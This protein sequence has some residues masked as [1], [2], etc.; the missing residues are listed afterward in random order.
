MTPQDLLGALNIGA[1]KT[2]PSVAKC[3]L[4]LVPG[5]LEITL[6]VGGSAVYACR[7]QTCGFAGDGLELFAR[8]KNCGLQEAA[9]ILLAGGILP[10][11]PDFHVHLQDYLGA[12]KAHQVID[13]WWAERNQRLQ[14]SSHAAGI[15]QALGC[16]IS[17]ALTLDPQ[18]L[19]KHLGICTGRELQTLMSGHEHLMYTQGYRQ[20]LITPLYADPRTITGFAY[21]TETDFGCAHLDS[22]SKVFGFGFLS[23]TGFRSDVV[24]LV[25]TPAAALEYLANSWGVPGAPGI[26]YVHP[27]ASA[28]ESVLARRRLFLNFNDSIETYKQTLRD[29]SAV[30]VSKKAIQTRHYGPLSS[31]KARLEYFLEI[32][33]TA[34]AA[35]G[36]YLLG[37]SFAEAR[38]AAQSMDLRGADMARISSA[39]PEASR[40][41]M[42]EIFA[43]LQEKLSVSYRGDTISIYNG[44][45]RS[46]K[47]GEISNAVFL[48]D[49]VICDTHNNRTVAKGVVL[50]GKQTYPFQDDLVRLQTKVVDFLQEVLRKNHGDIL[51]VA[52]GWTKGNKMY[53]LS[54]QFR[55]PQT[56]YS[57]VGTGWANDNKRLVLPRITL[58]NG[59]VV[60][61]TKLL[62]GS[63]QGLGIPPDL[64][65]LDLDPILVPSDA[66]ASFW[67]LWAALTANAWGPLQPHGPQGYGIV[68]ATGTAF[69]EVY[70]GMIESIGLQRVTLSTTDAVRTTKATEQ[71]SILPLVI[72]E[73][74]SHSKFF[75]AYQQDGLRNAFV[76]MSPTTYLATS[77]SGGWTYLTPKGVPGTGVDLRPYWALLPMFWAWLQVNQVQW[78]RTRSS[79]LPGILRNAVEPWL[80]SLG[81]E[82]PVFADKAVGLISVDTTAAQVAWGYRFMGFLI[83]ATK[84]GILRIG[85]PDDPKFAEN[86]TVDEAGKVA[87]VSKQRLGALFQELGIEPIRQEDIATNMDAVGCLVGQRY[88]NTVGIVMDLERY[89][90]CWAMRA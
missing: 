61:S 13:D 87:F 43:D 37:I 21:F 60:T 4:C 84:K 39:V 32:G 52:P 83:E 30:V 64:H 50:Q 22:H 65:T 1:G 19:G 57:A 48:V 18:G 88:R 15:L 76:G 89:N 42:E 68:E 20:Y 27:R 78:E 70:Q 36:A 9:H 85:K 86:L 16:W 26:L 11:D 44:S 49:E 90:L 17:P 77:L 56:T 71:K 63:G 25:N 62:D 12:Y 51:N 81:Y 80:R 35:A 23:T 2:Y 33:T 59:V 46:E 6:A 7:T 67:A 41:Q 3:P 38:V 82:K 5:A 53:H 34:H 40:P 66:S 14:T 24:V 8:A 28:W 72:D 74:W 73:M 10:G 79:L 47:H 75:A 69:D 45:W 31:P 55:A 54:T 29:S 58:E